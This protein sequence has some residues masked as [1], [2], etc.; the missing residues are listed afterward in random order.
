MTELTEQE[1]HLIEERISHELVMIR[2][3]RVYAE[4][5]EN[6]QVKAKCEQLAGMHRIHCQRMIHCLEQG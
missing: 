4:Q 2:K 3:C 5:A 1:L 6:P